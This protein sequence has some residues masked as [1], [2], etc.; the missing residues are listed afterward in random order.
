MKRPAPGARR[1]AIARAADP[2]LAGR[3]AAAP[4]LPR[5][6]GVHHRTVSPAINAWS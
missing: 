5:G 1:R 6:R 4:P 3:G 2:R